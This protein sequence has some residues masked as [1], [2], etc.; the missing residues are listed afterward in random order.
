[1]ATAPRVVVDSSAWIQHQRV[2]DPVIERLDA[3]GRLWSHATVLGEVRLG[4][5]APARALAGRVTA[6]PRAPSADP[7][8]VL[9][10]TRIAGVACSNIG[11]ADAE[12]VTTCVHAEV[13]TRIYTHDKHLQAVAVRLGVAFVA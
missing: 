12:L 9:A 10:L 4:C 3:E 2:G 6:C 7:D 8:Q 11:W 13:P 1:M 5:G